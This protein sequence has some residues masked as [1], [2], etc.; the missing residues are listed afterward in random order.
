MSGY[1][2]YLVPW[3]RKEPLAE[4]PHHLIQPGDG[5]GLH[6]VKGCIPKCRAYQNLRMWPDSEIGSL[7][8]YL[9]RMRSYGVVKAPIQHDRCPYQKARRTDR[10]GKE[11]TA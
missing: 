3:K 4:K 8:M 1:I 6:W 9:D 11:N 10:D 5:R 2:Q 7:Q